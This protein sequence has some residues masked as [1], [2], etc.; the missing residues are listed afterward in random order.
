ME[1]AHID[2]SSI[3]AAELVNFVVPH[4]GGFRLAK[5]FISEDRLKR[6][7]AA[8]DLVI[9]DEVRLL[10]LVSSAVASVATFLKRRKRSCFAEAE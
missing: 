3:L 8:S 7:A 2:A 9:A 5:K 4:L 10:E 6:L 1:P